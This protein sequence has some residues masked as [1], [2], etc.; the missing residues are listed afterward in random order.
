MEANSRTARFSDLVATSAATA[1]TRSRKEKTAI[2]ATFFNDVD[3]AHLPIAIAFLSGHPLQD[4]LGVGWSAV[5]NVDVAPA[6]TASL[7]LTEVDGTFAALE[8]TTGP[9]SQARRQELLEDLYAA[10]TAEEQD[11]LSRLLLRD[12]RQGATSGL[13]TDAIAKTADVSGTLMR[14]AAMLA[15]SLVDAGVVA[16]REG[17]PGLR[18]I[19]LELFRPVGPMLASTAESVGTGVAA[20]G[21]ASVEAKLD[22]ARIQVHKRA[23]DVA[24]YTRN[25]NDITSRVPEIVE[26]TKSLA[27]DDAI[28]DGEA[29]SLR[30]DGRP[31]PFQ[32]TMGRFGSETEDA[33][34]SRLALMPVFFDVLYADGQDLLDEP[35]SVRHT[36][37]DRLPV[38]LRVPRISTPDPDE[39][40]TFLADTLAAGHE[41]VM[42]KDPA[43]TYAAGRR[44]KAWL[45]VKPAHTLDLVV[46]AVEWGSGRRRGWLSNL[47]LAARDPEGGF[48]MLGKTF[49]GMTDAMLEWQTQRF[50]ELKTGEEGHVVHVRPEQVVEIAFD[51]IQ[52]SSRYPGGV[53]LR[54]ARVKGYRDDKGAAE[55]D[56]IETVRAIFERSA[57]AS[58]DDAK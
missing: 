2:L 50:L 40:A 41:G 12:L 53:A 29:V 54:F 58:E 18:D 28:L 39:A 35:L 22:G 16:L 27:F 34:A 36:M 38:E 43:S 10:A 5:R 33:P 19:R 20:F 31:E 11:F 4:K 15:G 1:A 47:H 14:R 13:M 21:E 55:A 9:G 32:V 25:L 52:A 37:L 56:T 45:K 24:V 49:K 46:I 48:V 44:G 7:T 42:V 8:S 26:L 51:G 17:A 3:P 57:R 23:G 30:S 6:A